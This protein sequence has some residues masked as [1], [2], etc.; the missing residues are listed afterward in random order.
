MTAAVGF[1][2]FLGSAV[3]TSAP[4]TLDTGGTTTVQELYELKNLTTD[5]TV[6]ASNDGGAT[7][8]SVEP[9][10]TLRMLTK[11]MAAAKIKLAGSEPIRRVPSLRDPNATLREYPY[12]VRISA[13]HSAKVA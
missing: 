8:H 10:R 12:R 5:A 6:L 11:L 4:L 3:T 9:G 2:E 7:W 13:L 1:F